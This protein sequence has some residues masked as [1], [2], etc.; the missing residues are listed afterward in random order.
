MIVCASTLELPEIKPKRGFC[1]NFFGI[2]RR[3]TLRHKGTKN[4]QHEVS[5]KRRKPEAREGSEGGR[6]EGRPRGT[7]G[8]RTLS[9]RPTLS[10]SWCA[11]CRW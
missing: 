8:G 7:R 2:Q 9:E 1:V 5:K 6:I 10:L 11:W 3:D 4:L